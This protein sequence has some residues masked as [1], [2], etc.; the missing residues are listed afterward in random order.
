MTHTALAC[1]TRCCT[2]SVYDMYHFGSIAVAISA[3][4]CCLFTADL[5][6]SVCCTYQRVSSQCIVDLCAKQYIIHQKL[7][8]QEYEQIFT[9]YRQV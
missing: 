6:S 1:C 2:K 3:G 9:K 4:L 5:L 7:V 8:R